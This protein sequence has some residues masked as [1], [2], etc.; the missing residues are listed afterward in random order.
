MA[1]ATK[2]VD[3]NGVLSVLLKRLDKTDATLAALMTTD[4]KVAP[5][6]P[7]KPAVVAA[8][9]APLEM[10]L[11]PIQGRYEQGVGFRFHGRKTTRFMTVSEV[12]IVLKRRV[13]IEA[14]LAKLPK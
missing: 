5:A 2:N 6:Q 10:E 11:E 7:A 14:A 1:K 12:R 9:R 4:A 13:E 8:A 3:V